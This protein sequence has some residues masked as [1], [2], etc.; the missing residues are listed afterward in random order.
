MSLCHLSIYALFFLVFILFNVPSFHSTLRL[1][2]PSALPSC[3]VFGDWAATVQIRA[4][5]PSIISSETSSMNETITVVTA[6]HSFSLKT[7]G[8]FPR[9]HSHSRL[10]SSSGPKWKY[11]EVW[12]RCRTRNYFMFAQTDSH[13]FILNCK[14]ALAVT[15]VT[16]SKTQPQLEGCWRNPEIPAWSNSTLHF[17]GSSAK[18]R[19][20]GCGET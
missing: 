10:Y 3:E 14:L 5:L 4:G 16:M 18:L 15:R 9:L 6:V 11:C 12:T 19:M 13:P 20:S 2:L 17:P 7:N 1:S 8:D